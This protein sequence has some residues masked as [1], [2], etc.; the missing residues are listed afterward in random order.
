MAT[1]FLSFVDLRQADFG[2]KSYAEISFDE[3]R[4]I[5]TASTIDAEPIRQRPQSK[6]A[7]NPSRSEFCGLAEC[8]KEL[9]PSRKRFCCDAHADTH[10]QRKRREVASWRKMVEAVS[11]FDFEKTRELVTQVCD[12]ESYIQALQVAAAQ[13]TRNG[14]AQVDLTFVG[15]GGYE[16]NMA[17]RLISA[18]EIQAERQVVEAFT[19]GARRGYLRGRRRVAI[20]P[21]GKDDEPVGRS[22]ADPFEGTLRLIDDDGV[23]EKL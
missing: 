13:S 19:E 18:G 15:I 10:R 7:A 2:R 6:E 4:T 12:R 22:E 11:P 16:G 9:P 8:P 14:R 17:T 5:A 1:W 3:P 21:R 20:L 23:S